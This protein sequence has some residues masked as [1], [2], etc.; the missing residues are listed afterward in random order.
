MSQAPEASQAPVTTAKASLR[1]VERRRS[2]RLLITVPIRVE[3]VDRNGEKFTEET[4]TIVV[5]RQ[6]AR[7][8]LRRLVSAGAM[9]LITTN[10]A[11]RSGKFRVVGPTKPPSGD[12]G[13]WGI[14]S[15]EA[16]C[17]IWGIGFP[18]ASSSE[19]ECT[20]LL[21]CRRC[22][23][24]KLSNLSRVE[25]EVLGNSGL[26]VKECEACAR[27]TSWTYKEPSVPLATEDEGTVLPSPETLAEQAA[28]RNHRLHNRVALQLPLRV[29]G[30]YG[31][32]EFTRTENVSR[33]GVC[34]I[35][36]R[37]Y[38]VG[39]VILVT[40]P[41]EKSGHNIEVRGHVVR[42]RDMQGTGRKIYGVSYER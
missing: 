5:N 20:A 36:D 28:G 40:C 18:P 41:F 32:E 23:S 34:F 16:I 10:V 27:S 42:R 1:E 6:G 13:E 2:E 26:L 31:A 15:Q 25:H 24:V 7:I 22:H 19:G 11:H 9:L 38:E 17:N 37:N 39:E 4:R 14:E 12:G 30:F 3:G 33:G 35:T 29:R 8:Y 21:E